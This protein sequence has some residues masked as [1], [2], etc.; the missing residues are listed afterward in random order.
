MNS[1]GIL[2]LVFFSFSYSLKGGGT[3]A[4]RKLRLWRR[5]GFTL[6]ELLVVIAIIGVLI[7]LLLPAVQKVREAAN[8]TQCSNNLKQIGLG[9]HNFHDTYGRFP[10]APTKGWNELPNVT[11]GFNGDFGIAYDASGAPLGVKTQ[12]AAWCFQIL[13]FIEQDNLYKTND[14]NLQTGAFDNRMSL[15]GSTGPIP[16]PVVP[17]NFDG[18]TTP[19]WSSGTW[20]TNY[21]TQ[22]GPTDMG[23]VK[24]YACP[25]RRA[26]QLVDTWRN[27]TTN[28]NNTNFK[29][30]FIDYASVRSCPVPMNQP[31]P[32][33]DVANHADWAAW[34]TT[35]ITGEARRSVIAPMQSKV[36]FASI[37]DG[38]SNTMVVAEKW[39]QPQGYGGDGMDDDGPW[40]RGE[41]DITRNTG[42]FI[43]TSSGDNWRTTAN[44]ARD[45]INIGD[46][47]NNNYWGQYGVFGAAHPAGIN[48][49]FGDGSVHSVKFGIDPQTFNA[50]GRMDDG[51]NLH[52]DPDNIQ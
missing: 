42:V 52:A 23:V 21:A 26:P 35:W 39:K 36:T 8:R 18:G 10:S 17:N 11:G 2:H 9:I 22:P 37:K 3:N 15:V 25:S 5:I 46:F 6:V 47:W 51:T 31:N 43:S 38:S 27:D 12:T 20:F 50:L 44:P 1:F 19:V 4:M 34:A 7:A 13:P 33:P 45:D 30:A 40:M 24:I 49:V 14:W 41:D 16:N 48:A 29:R 32:S 28:N